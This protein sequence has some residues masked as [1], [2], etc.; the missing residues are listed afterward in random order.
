MSPKLKRRRICPTYLILP[1]TTKCIIPIAGVGRKTTHLGSSISDPVVAQTSLTQSPIH[2][3]ARVDTQLEQLLWAEFGIHVNVTLARHGVMEDS[4][5]QA[6]LL[7]R[8]ASL[9][10]PSTSCRARAQRG[11]M[12]SSRPA[13]CKHSS[14]RA[15]RPCFACAVFD[16]PWLPLDFSG[17]NRAA[18]AKWCR[19]QPQ[20]TSERRQE[21]LWTGSACTFCMPPGVGESGMPMC[22]C[23]WRS[24]PPRCLALAVKLCD[25][26][27]GRGL[28]TPGLAVFLADH[29]PHA[30]HDPAFELGGIKPPQ[31]PVLAG[32]KLPFLCDLP[33]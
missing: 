27:A 10:A 24:R 7:P 21:T 33:T 23:R 28:A 15:I 14:L 18:A 25:T 30:Q 32:S 12:W 17:L 3:R 11:P 5:V 6:P 29:L 31:L 1:Y 22:L 19:N 26:L 20:K 16:R 13:L 8:I 2:P 9:V 4:G